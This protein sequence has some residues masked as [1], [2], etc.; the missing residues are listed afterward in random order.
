MIK[1]S[2]L[3]TKQVPVH[4]TEI[5]PKNIRGKFTSANQV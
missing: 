5:T 2:V 3:I 1:F 4:V